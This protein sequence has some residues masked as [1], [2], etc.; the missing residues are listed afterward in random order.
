M[1]E[2]AAAPPDK[3]PQAA[4]SDPD[5]AVVIAVDRG[6]SDAPQPGEPTG[7]TCPEC[8]GGIW[9][10]VEDGLTRLRCRTGH[11]YAP[12]TF[13]V[14][15]SERVEAALWTA[16]R[17][18]EERAALHR[19]IA[20]RQRERGNLRTA[21]RFATR[22]EESVEQALVLRRLLGDLGTLRDDEGVA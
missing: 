1:A 21:G 10:S 2:L 12:E 18:L 15:Q 9:E 5:P 22:A 14:A 11:E 17:T 6:S 20:A 19:R 16:L 3:P 13:V 7:L 8:N 4:G